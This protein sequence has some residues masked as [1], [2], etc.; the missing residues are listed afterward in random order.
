MFMSVCF[1]EIYFIRKGRGC[2]G[3]F[4][5]DHKIIRFLHKIVMDRKGGAVIIKVHET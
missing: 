4:L 3:I 2:K 1:D 5:D